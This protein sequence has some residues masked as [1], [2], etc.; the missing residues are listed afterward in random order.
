MARLA[1]LIQKLL[2]VVVQGLGGCHLPR[3]HAVS[4]LGQLHK[5]LIRP[6]CSRFVNIKRRSLS[7]GSYVCNWGSPFLVGPSRRT[8][9]LPYR[10]TL[11]GLMHVVWDLGIQNLKIGQRARFIALHILI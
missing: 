2:L 8:A 1:V 3:R 4:F 7:F 9:S 10:T 6:I 5:L 11:N